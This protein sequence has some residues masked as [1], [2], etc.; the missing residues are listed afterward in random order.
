MILQNITLTYGINGMSNKRFQECGWPEKL[1]RSRHYLS[2]PYYSAK[3]YMRQVIY[4]PDELKNIWG[5]SLGMAQVEMNYVYTSEEVF[6]HLEAHLPTAAEEDS[7]ESFVGRLKNSGEYNIESLARRSWRLLLDL[8]Q[9][10]N[11]YENEITNLSKK[12]G[13]KNGH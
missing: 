5:M 2:V 4:R 1:W 8:E 9:T 7:F 11:M 3:S 6:E 10:V 13:L 12:S